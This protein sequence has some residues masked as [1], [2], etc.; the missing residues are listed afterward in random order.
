V[1]RHRR[2]EVVVDK[3]PVQRRDVEL[4]PIVMDDGIRFIKKRMNPTNHCLHTVMVD[5]REHDILLTLPLSRPTK[6]IPWL[7]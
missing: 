3:L 1:I 4:L 5:G 2:G 7:H 6:G